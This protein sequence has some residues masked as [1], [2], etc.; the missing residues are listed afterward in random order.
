[1]KKKIG[2]VVALLLFTG[3]GPT[4]SE[5]ALQERQQEQRREWQEV[6]EYCRQR[7]LSRPFPPL[8]QGERLPLP[9]YLKR[10]RPTWTLAFTECFQREDALLAKYGQELNVWG[11]AKRAYK[12]AVA[13]KVDSKQISPA[14]GNNLIAQFNLQLETTRQQ[15]AAQQ[16]QARAAEQ[17]AAAQEA[18]AQAQFQAAWNQM[19]QNMYPQQTPGYRPPVICNYASYGSGMGNITCY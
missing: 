18:T 2:S 14:D 6:S 9:E 19:W 8:Q 17:S 15:L 13:E 5:L 7:P 16:T 11:R 12:M 10:L 3:C 1:M 4:A